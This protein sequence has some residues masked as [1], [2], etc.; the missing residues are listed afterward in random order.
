MPLLVLWGFLEPF[1]EAIDW[2][3]LAVPAGVLVI[4]SISY[5][6]A[7]KLAQRGVAVQIRELESKLESEVETH[8]A[9]RT[10]IETLR[11]QQASHAATMQAQL[12]SIKSNEVRLAQTRVDSA[13]MLFEGKKLYREVL[14]LREMKKEYERLKQERIANR[15]KIEALEDDSIGKDGKLTALRDDLTNR[16]KL[17]EQAE[18]RMKRARRLSGYLVKAKALVA[19][20]KFK[21]LADRKRA[22]IAVAALKGGVGKTTL[23]AHLAGAM[24]RKGYRVLLVDLDLQ[25]SLTGLMLPPD[26][27]SARVKQK[28]L[29]QDFFVLAMEHKA[30]KLTDFIV[31]SPQSQGWPG[32]ISIVPTS[33][34]LAYA[35]LNLTLGWL[36]K[37]GERDARFLLR[38]AL[39]M[40]G[41]NADFDIVLL[42]CPPVLNIS[43]ANAFAAS[44]YLLIPTLL[45]A[46]SSERVPNLI[47]AVQEDHFLKHLNSQLRILGVVA[48]RTRYAELKSQEAVNWSNQLPNALAAIQ[49]QHTKLFSTIVAQDTEISSNE[50]QFT[51]PKTGGRAHTMFT[52]LLTELEQELPHD[53]RI[54]RAANS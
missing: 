46:K 44:D 30:T 5:Y 43:C 54:P 8:A 3:K 17:M 19:R 49:K 29:L 11:H 35:E 50:E 28:L 34:Q 37:Q 53:C 25:G 2:N 21:P 12:S 10:T 27:I 41:A 38:R 31:R 9:A 14:G 20:P 1:I 51:H 13:K 4:F 48:N 39:H 16:E 33:D 7:T 22:I 47:K 24:A 23:T 26:T 36:L 42:D 15:S 40:K 32:S 45:S 6:V 52:Q 18:R